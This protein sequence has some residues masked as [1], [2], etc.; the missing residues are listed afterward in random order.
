MTTDKTP[1]T[2]AVDVLAV[3]ARD[4]ASAFEARHGDREIQEF[5]GKESDAARVAVAELIEAAYLLH[6]LGISNEE[7]PDWPAGWGWVR[8]HAALA[9]VKGESA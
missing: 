8:I 1:A 4:A 9:R 6:A 7:F 5:L 3:M 2:L